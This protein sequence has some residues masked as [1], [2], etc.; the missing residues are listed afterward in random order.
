MRSVRVQL[1]VQLN[2]T[3]LP[4]THLDGTGHRVANEQQAVL[5]RQGPCLDHLA[6]RQGDLGARRDVEAGLDN[7]VVAQ[8]DPDAGVGAEQ[9]TL[10]DRDDFRAACR[11][12]VPMIEAPPPTSES[13]PTTTPAEMRPSTIEVPRV[14]ALK[15]TKPSCITVVPSAEVGAQPDPVSVGDAYARRQRRSRPCAGT[16]PRRRW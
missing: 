14:P 12:S 4:T 1:G 6:A 3:A 15:L 11:T 13:R 10:A 8:G 7:A 9:A 16:C 5:T 2:S